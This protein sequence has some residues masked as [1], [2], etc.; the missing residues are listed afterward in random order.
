VGGAHVTVASAENPGFWMADFACGYA[1]KMA[2]GS[3][4]HSVKIKLQVDNL[5]NRDVQILNSV[6][7][8]PAANTYNVL[9]TTNYFIT[10]STEF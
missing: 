4:L 9:P 1:L 10:L 2:P 8:T 6:G 3:H 5:L 7:S